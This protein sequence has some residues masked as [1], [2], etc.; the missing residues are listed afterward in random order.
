[1]GKPV[2]A[3]TSAPSAPAASVGMSKR[4]GKASSSQRW[5]AN[6]VCMHCQGKGHRRGSSHN[7]FPTQVYF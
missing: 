1:M 4:K 5:R 6:D 7:S 2:A 3:T